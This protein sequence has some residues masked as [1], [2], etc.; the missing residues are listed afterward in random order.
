MPSD[1]DRIEISDVAGG[2]EFPLKVVPNASRTRV[3][4]VLG[5][6]LKIA[7]SAP[8]EGGRANAQVI[9]LLA[10]LF[11]RRRAEVEIR[12]GAARPAKRIFV[13]GLR[14]ADIRRMVA[15][16]QPGDEA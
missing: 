10:E 1:V 14:A 11:G 9:K 15:A 3:A 6:A 12:G 5:G 4:G 13:A 8:P 7:V 2:V 16:L